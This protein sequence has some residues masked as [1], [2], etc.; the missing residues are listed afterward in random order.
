MDVSYA[1]VI[2]YGYV[3][4]KSAET[5]FQPKQSSVVMMGKEVLNR[6]TEVVVRAE[7]RV[8]CGMLKSHKC[9]L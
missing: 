4:L 2:S 9:M 3:T 5:I 6:S 1:F 8:S 7:L